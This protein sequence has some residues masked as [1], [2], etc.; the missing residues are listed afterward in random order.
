MIKVNGANDKKEFYLNHKRIQY[1]KIIN[2]VAHITMD[3]GAV[4]IVSNS[5]D[6]IQSRILN[7]ESANIYTAIVNMKNKE[8]EEEVN[9]CCQDERVISMKRN[10]K[11]S[12]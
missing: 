9:N 5:I 10:K 2:N 8:I 4:Y 1:I 6:E 7:I 3:N 12:N 11:S